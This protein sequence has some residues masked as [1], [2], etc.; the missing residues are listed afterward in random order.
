MLF[1]DMYRQRVVGDVEETQEGM[2]LGV[3]LR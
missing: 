2:R 3:S 1:F